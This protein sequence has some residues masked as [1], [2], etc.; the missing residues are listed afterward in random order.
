M[1]CLGYRRVPK[2]IGRD[3]IEERKCN[4]DEKCAEE[5]IPEEDNFFVFH[6]EGLLIA[7]IYFKEARS[8]TNRY[9]TSPFTI[10]SYAWFIC[11]MGMT[12]TSGI[13]LCLAQ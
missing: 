10:R 5:K 7:I 9:R 4:A 6:A 13:I 8:I 11:W 1:R 12:S 3:K 2:N